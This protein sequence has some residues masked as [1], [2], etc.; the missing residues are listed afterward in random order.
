VTAM[1]VVYALKRQ[2]RTLYGFGG[3]DW[4]LFA[5]LFTMVFL[6]TTSSLW[7]SPL[8]LLGWCDLSLHC[9]NFH[10]F[11]CFGLWLMHRLLTDG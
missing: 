9:M 2:G 4:S 10:V 5:A 7:L 8:I 11:W 3:W 1:D 6:N